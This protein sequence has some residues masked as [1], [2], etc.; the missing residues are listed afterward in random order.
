MNI[1]K[2]I[3]GREINAAGRTLDV[4][5]LLLKMKEQFTVRLAVFK[6]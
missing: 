1:G 5:T 4:Q 3:L 6:E 2:E